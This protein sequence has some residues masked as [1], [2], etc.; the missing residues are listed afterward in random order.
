MA[1]AN[2]RAMNNGRIS[3]VRPVANSLSAVF[4][5]APFRWPHLAVATEQ[6]PCDCNGSPAVFTALTPPARLH[7]ICS[8]AERTAAPY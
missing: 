7:H 2:I 4:M 8:A 3:K 6:S 1:Q 5:W